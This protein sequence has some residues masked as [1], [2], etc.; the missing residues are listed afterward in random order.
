MSVPVVKPPLSFA[1]RLRRRGICTQTT[2]AAS[3]T[4]AARSCTCISLSREA[5]WLP[6]KDG[7]GRSSLPDLELFAVSLTWVS[8]SPPPLPSH[9][10]FTLPSPSPRAWYSGYRALCALDCLANVSARSEE[11]STLGSR[12]FLLSE[13]WGRNHGRREVGG[14]VRA[15]LSESEKALGPRLRAVRSFLE[16]LATQAMYA[17]YG[18][19]P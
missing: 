5:D 9:S 11:Q 12:E 6:S 7:R 13:S 19:G 17:R 15:Q 10:A 8:G 1:C 16:A 4:R 2:G 14:E 3:T 18:S